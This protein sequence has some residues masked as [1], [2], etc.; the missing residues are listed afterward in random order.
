MQINANPDVFLVQYG[1]SANNNNCF[2]PET[3]NLMQTTV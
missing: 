1:N 2:S 3:Q